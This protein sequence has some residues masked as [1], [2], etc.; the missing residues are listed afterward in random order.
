[1]TQRRTKI[2][3]TIGP[4]SRSPE[5]LR[6]LIE[7]G[8]N[9]V[10]LN[11]AH[12]DP[13]SH[14]ATAATAREQ[15]DA[16]GRVV[17]VLADLPGPKMRTG[18]VAGDAVV[19]EAGRP[20]V[21]TGERVVGNAERVSTTVE[22]LSA[23]VSPGDEI[24]L[25]DGYIALRVEAVEER[26]V[27][28]MVV[29]RG[30]LRSGKGMHLPGSEHRVEAF[31]AADRTALEAVIEMDADFV[32]LSFARDAKDVARVL[33]ALPR[34]PDPPMLVAKIETASGV[35]NLSEIVREAD[36]VMVARG[37]LGIQTP[38]H[39]VP[40]LQKAIIRTCNDAGKPVITATQMLE[41]MTHSPLPSR[42]EV[43]DVANAVIDG[44]DA[45][46]LSEETAVGEFPID[47][48]R[49]MGASGA[50]IET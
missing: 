1:M 3:A 7:A 17:G 25:A 33:E 37:D 20:F 30:L 34:N 41:S 13:E 35:E 48:V 43:G 31:T 12:A 36:A 50:A 32:G 28:T 2:V 26:A 45:L 29:G 8:V 18:P 24:F 19:L 46:M 40:L 16:I 10:R 39:Q 47:V 27:H 22:E 49:T 21:L 14:V 42:A 11:L 9:V 5:V 15:G 6:A 44:T 23:I 4:R 38:L